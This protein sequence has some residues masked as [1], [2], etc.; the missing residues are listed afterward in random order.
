MANEFPGQIGPRSGL[1]QDLVSFEETG[2]IIGY[3]F[4]GG[5]IVNKH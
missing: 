2:P 1:I 5:G 3:M 4:D